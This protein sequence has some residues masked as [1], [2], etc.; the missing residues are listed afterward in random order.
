MTFLGF[1]NSKCIVAV[2][3]L[4]VVV[5]RAVKKHVA[6]LQ[7]ELDHLRM[8]LNAQC[9]TDLLTTTKSCKL[10]LLLIKD[11]FKLIPVASWSAHM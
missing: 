9:N 10:E 6:L 3:F 11:S 2:Q 8:K 5:Q 7:T 4:L 1:C